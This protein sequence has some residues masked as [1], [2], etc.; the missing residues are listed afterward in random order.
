MMSGS[1]SGKSTSSK[2]L[3]KDLFKGRELKVLPFFPLAHK[4]AAKVG[5]VDPQLIW[6]DPA[7]MVNSLLTTKE[8]CKFGVLTTSIDR[9]GC[10]A[11]ASGGLLMQMQE[12]AGVAL[13][14]TQRLK[15]ML[16]DSTILGCMAAGPFTLAGGRSNSGVWEGVEKSFIEARDHLLQQ[17]KLMG[18]SRIDFLMLHEDGLD[19][20]ENAVTEYVEQIRP[21][22]NALRYYDVQPILALKGSPPHIIE[23]L[24]PEVSG[25]AIMDNIFE[26][27]LEWLSR[28]AEQ[29]K[30]CIGLALPEEVF[31]GSLEMMETILG[32][33]AEHFNRRRIFLLPS[34]EIPAETEICNIQDCMKKLG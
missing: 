12:R 31:K 9:A 16:G 18:E 3:F 5:Q 25:I 26:L 11:D 15:H 2:K 14:V 21:L 22:W 17:I 24:A 33:I 23:S 4:L 29:E 34:G 20:P 10:E 19:V 30:I 13:E 8:L 28:I 1:F 27:D 32:R 7:T 6:G